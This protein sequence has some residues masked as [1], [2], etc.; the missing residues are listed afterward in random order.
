MQNVD[1]Y[2]GSNSHNTSPQFTRS[3]PEFFTRMSD[4]RAM[5]HDKARRRASSS[6]ARNRWLR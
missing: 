2:T 3:D 6:P 1:F 4:N 5:D